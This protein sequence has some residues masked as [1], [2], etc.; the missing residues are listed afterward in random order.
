M[1]SWQEDQKGDGSD[2]TSRSSKKKSKNLLLKRQ[3]LT[4]ILQTFLKDGVP[5]I[6]THLS[7]TIDTSSKLFIFPVE[8]IVT[9]LFKNQI[10]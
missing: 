10:S 1:T 6:A 9:E 2:T 5:A 3:K 7:K 4:R 8:C